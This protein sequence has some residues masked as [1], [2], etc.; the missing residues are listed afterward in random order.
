[1][2]CSRECA[3]AGIASGQTLADARSLLPTAHFTEHEPDADEA[4][5]KR[6]AW[7]CQQFSPYVGIERFAGL[8]CLVMDVTGGTHLFGGDQLLARQVIEFLAGQQFFAHV[9]IASSIG[10]AWG[11]AR[12]GH[13]AGTSRTLRSL[14][15][16][17]LRLPDDTL[18]RLRSF[19]LRRVKQLLELP[20]QELPARFGDVLNNRLDQL[21]GK[22]SEEITLERPPEPTQARWSA[23]DGISGQHAV[24]YVC[25]ELLDEILAALEPRREGVL[26]LRLEFRS[27]TA[28]TCRFEQG[29]AQPATSRQHLLDLLKLR[30]EKEHLPAELHT[31]CMTAVETSP[32]GTRQQTLFEE[33]S[34]PADGAFQRLLDRLT[35]RLGVDAVLRAELRQD[36][37]PEDSVALL[38]VTEPQTSLRRQQSSPETSETN[39]DAEQ[40]PTSSRPL[41]LMGPV[42]VDVVCALRNGPPTR[43][44]WQHGDYTIAQCTEPERIDT[45]WW[46]VGGHHARTYYRVETTTGERFWL[47]RNAHG[48][49]YLHGVFD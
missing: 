22:C 32:L 19:D 34:L 33:D 39:H 4:A 44:R 1:M 37:L 10:A 31:I 9:S 47:F 42:R 28:A 18:T 3:D 7:S 48:D 5:L 49:W 27:D 30:L 26:R 6:L 12:Y 36:P 17:S 13:Q 29:I 21:F 46:S 11:I 45:G 25:G 40:L 14:P 41:C 23:D 35:S 24:A 43:F 2:A 8:A 20:R 15:I 16:E 38:P